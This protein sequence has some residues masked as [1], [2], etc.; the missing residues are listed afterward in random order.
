MNNAQTAMPLTGEILPPEIAAAPAVQTTVTGA[1][2]VAADALAMVV[3]TPEDYQRAAEMAQRIAA[4]IA[5]LEKERLGLT[6]PMDEAKK[7]LM[8]WFRGPTAK[9]ESAQNELRK[10]MVAFTTEQKRIADEQRR[11]AEQKERERQAEIQRQADEQVR[12][13]NE[14][15]AAAKAAE[16][17]AEEETAQQRTA[18]LRE[19]NRRQQEVDEA[20]ERARHL[21]AS[22]APQA[23]SVPV[24][25]PVT[26]KGISQRQVAKYEIVNKGMIPDMFWLIDEKAIAAIVRSQGLRAVE[27]VPG[28]RVWMEDDISVRAKS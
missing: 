16:K 28:I 19:E 27:A 10:R 18:R 5:K 4:G 26:A 21:Q 3:S 6:R 14:A 12:I 2:A 24:A 8:D 1:E 23:I 17:P 13:A 11:E 20:L 7:R 25:A 22:A 9:L 15:A